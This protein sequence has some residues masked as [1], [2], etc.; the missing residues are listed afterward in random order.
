M[1]KKLF[2]FVV[3]IATGL[4]SAQDKAYEFNGK[5]FIASYS[6]CDHEA[7]VNLEYLREAMVNAVEASGASLLGQ[8]DYV[9]PTDGLTMVLLLSE[10]HASIH[11]YPEYNTCFIDLFTCDEK[12]S[13]EAF[14]AVLQE[15]LKPEFIEKKLLLRGY[16]VKELL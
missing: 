2:L 3:F 4:L 9:F 13:S 7:L 11:T 14:D 6:G 1:I 5:H 12:C 16:D 10:S 15:Y 8:C